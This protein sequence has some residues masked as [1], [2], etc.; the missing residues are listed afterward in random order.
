M[1]NTHVGFR[2]MTHRWVHLLVLVVMWLGLAV[3]PARA[4]VVLTLSAHPGEKSLGVYIYYPHAFLRLRGTVD[5]TGEVIDR[6]VGFGAQ[7]FSESLLF[8][9]APGEISEPDAHLVSTG[10][11]Y[12]RLTLTDDMYRA[13]VQRID[14]WASSEGS[15]YN[16]RR[17]NCTHFVMDIAELVGLRLPRIQALSPNGTMI[18]TAALNPQYSLG[19]RGIAHVNEEKLPDPNAP[20]LD[21]VPPDGAEPEVPELINKPLP[22]D[23]VVPTPA[24]VP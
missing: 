24:V 20:R 6:F 16:L 3:V 22:A 13:V 19:P 17:R 23:G 10:T 2:R 18:A 21:A 5:G 12:I 15:T 4:E 1:I 8:R 11:D 9:S 14:Y 7:E